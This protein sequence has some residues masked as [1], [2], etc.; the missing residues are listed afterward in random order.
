MFLQSAY[1]TSSSNA[2]SFEGF[3]KNV[4]SDQS[5][6]FVGSSGSSHDSQT[7]HFDSSETSVAGEF[8]RSALLGAVRESNSE[9]CKSLTS[10]VDEPVPVQYTPTMMW[11][12]PCV[13][14]S[15]AGFLLRDFARN[16]SLEAKKCGDANCTQHGI[17]GPKPPDW[18]D[19]KNFINSVADLYADD[20][21]ANPC[22]CI[23][24]KDTGANWYG[25][26]CSR[27]CDSAEKKDPDCMKRSNLTR[28]EIETGTCK[29]CVTC[30]HG[31]TN[32]PN[33][34]CACQCP[35][36]WG[37]PVCECT[38]EGFVCNDFDAGCTK[39]SVNCCAGLAFLCY[40]A[41]CV[42]QLPP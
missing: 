30:Q 4:S 39:E 7:K 42:C 24:D 25:K 5:S 19:G 11:D 41:S 38:K 13:Q 36:R 18:W 15:P 8:V 14:S 33:D 26:D 28:C 17:C 27:E 29:P 21:T 20:G 37:G 10:T 16:A 9:Q 31:G 35:A 2:S 1:T 32:N 34:S 40:R 12:L 6:F 3:R 23:P 22:M